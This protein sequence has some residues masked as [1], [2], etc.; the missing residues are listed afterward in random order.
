M[1][2][3]MCGMI[4]PTEG[5]VKIDGESVRSNKHRIGYISQTDTLLPWRKIESNVAL[6]LEIEKI[7]KKERM[8]RAREMMRVSGLRI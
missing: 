4:E 7:P 1:L 2:N 5:E 3:I 8:E 6:G